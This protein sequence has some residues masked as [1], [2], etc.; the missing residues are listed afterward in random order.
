MWS[1][2][3][4]H[5]PNFPHQ[6]KEDLSLLANALYHSQ[7]Q[8]Q[9]LQIMNQQANFGKPA[10]IAIPQAQFLSSF[11]VNSLLNNTTNDLF[12]N[13]LRHKKQQQSQLATNVFSQHFV[14]AIAANY[15]MQQLSRLNELGLQQPAAKKQK[16][17]DENSSS[18]SS[19][20]SS[21]SLLEL[22]QD[23]V[24]SKPCDFTSNDNECS[25]LNDSEN[26]CYDGK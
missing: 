1:S 13:Q 2:I 24:I 6:I 17:D 15:R 26:D 20:S 18:V 23:Y 4:A 25:G 14:S 11:S 7:Q 22:S 3:P 10:Q 19:T 5:Q 16:K 8:Q 21:S 12:S 9:Q